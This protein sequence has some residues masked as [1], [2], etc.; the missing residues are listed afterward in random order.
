MDSPTPGKGSAE[1][2]DLATLEEDLPT[3]AEDVS[4]LRRARHA[5]AMT[6]AEIA[7]AVRRLGP[8]APARLR[9]RR[10]PR[11]EPFEL[12]AEPFEPSP[13]PSC[14]DEDA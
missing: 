3:T 4:A 14:Q 12:P 9:A 5:S 1:P 8:L 2:S 7:R 11:G 10:G 6:P 13:D